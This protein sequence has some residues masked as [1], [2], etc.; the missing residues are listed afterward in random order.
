MKHHIKELS[1][2]LYRGN[3]TEEEIDILLSYFN[4]HDLQALEEEIRKEWD[5][6]QFGPFPKNLQQQIWRNIQIKTREEEIE[7]VLP[8]KKH[9]WK[10]YLKYAAIFIGIISLSLFFF[11]NKNTEPEFKDAITVEFEDG[12]I[13]TFNIENGEKA[14]ESGLV[15]KNNVLK[16]NDAISHSSQVE[17][18]T[19]RIPYGKKF[20]LELSDGTRIHLNAGSTLR[21]PFQFIKGKDRTVFLTGEAFFQV[22]RGEDKFTV[23]TGDIETEVLGT[24]FNVSSYGN[25]TNTEIVLLEGSVQVH[26]D[27]TRVMVPNEKLVHIAATG[28]WELETVDAA[29]YVS[30]RD[31]VLWFR[32]EPFNEIIP[33][34]ERHYNI[35]LANRYDEIKN[36]RFTGRFEREGI[37]EVLNVFKMALDFK[38]KISQQN[39]TILPPENK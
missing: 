16:Y 14:T 20:Q 5:F 4:S 24:E 6:D 2:K 35:E 17:Y 32:N 39:I 37:E 27:E 33:K 18:H 36:K 21:Y 11:Q 23:T 10:P 8:S 38:Y 31:G 13:E 22:T 29:D 30:W 26:G 9:S 7:L 3:C 1:E 34:L 25:N 12:K 28:K 19:I 15:Y